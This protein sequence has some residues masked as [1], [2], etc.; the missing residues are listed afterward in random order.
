M[1]I[2]NMISLKL[3]AEELKKLDDALTA[4]EEVVNNKFINLTPDERQLHGRVNN[5]TE[6]W[7]GKVRDYME[8]NPALVLAHV[9]VQE[10]NEDLEARRQLMPRMRRM[11][12]LFHRFEDTGML[13]GSDLYHNAITYY[14]GLKAASAT[15]APGAKTIYADLSARFPGRPTT[16]KTPMTKPPM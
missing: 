2:D 12:S 4:I 1:A 5:K 7:I 11:E 3:T 6:D 9:D 8:Q 15:D 14:K 16:A 10:Y 13:L